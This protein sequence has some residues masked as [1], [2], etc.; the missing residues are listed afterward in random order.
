MTLARFRKYALVGSITVV[1]AAA[2]AQTAPHATIPAHKSAVVLFNG[3]DLSQFDTFIRG[4]GLN[5]DPEHV[6]TVENGV[7]HVS[8]REMGYIVTKKPFHRF[9]LRAEFKWGEEGTIR[10]TRRT[11]PRQRDSLQHPGRSEGVASL[12]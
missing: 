11:G 4:R 9:Y 8:G 1:C 12:D 10:R 5:S 7:I 6:F 2:Y 3:S